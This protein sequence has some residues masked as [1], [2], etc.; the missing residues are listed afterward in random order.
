[1]MHHM[2]GL[3]LGYGGLALVA[4]KLLQMQAE[5]ARS[6]D[7][8]KLR[9]YVRAKHPTL[10]LDPILGNLEEES[11]QE[12]PGITEKERF[13]ELPK[14]AG[15]TGSSIGD[16]VTRAGGSV[17]KNQI[18]GNQDPAHLAFAVA[19]ALAG[20]VGGWKLADYLADKKRKT[21]LDSRIAGA[22]DRIDKLLYES[23]NQKKAGGSFSIKDAPNMSIPSSADAAGNPGGGFGYLANPRNL[24]HGGQI[25]WWMWAVA[26]FA[27]AY[28]A[29]KGFGDN[30]DPNRRRVKELQ[31]IASDRAK[32]KAAPVLMEMS[33]VPARPSVK[34]RRVAS[35]NI[36]PKT[37]T[38]APAQVPPAGDVDK[39]MG[40]SA[41]VVDKN[42]PYAHLLTM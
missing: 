31:E 40:K 5:K 2:G 37:P 10:S 7:D 42:D 22:S 11:E 27:L 23:M 3:A 15:L 28:K 19:A 1:M 24:L 14:V 38:A 34:T 39:E 6:K 20:G 32:M 29:A 9:S 13:P 12:A 4:R 18:T 36:D 8:D 26:S 35:E 30:K 16:S 33:T 25:A 17:V 21:E 41:P